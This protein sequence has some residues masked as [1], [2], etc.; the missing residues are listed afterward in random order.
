MIA[1]EVEN[2]TCGSCATSVTRAL[3]SLDPAAKVT[4]DLS[5][6]RVHIDGTRPPGDY[7]RAL[8]AAGFP[9]RTS[10]AARDRATGCCGGC[11]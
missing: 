6:Q 8:D 9:A 3:H 7:S 2:M 4:V 1:L 10:T 5:Q 11:S